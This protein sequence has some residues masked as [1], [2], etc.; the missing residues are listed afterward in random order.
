[1]SR[2]Q[3]RKLER[4][5]RKVGYQ[6]KVTNPIQGL[7]K[8]GYK[9][10]TDSNGKIKVG[11]DKSYNL[12][13]GLNSPRTETFD[14]SKIQ[15]IDINDIKNYNSLWE[16]TKSGWDSEPNTMVYPYINVDGEWLRWDNQLMRIDGG[17]YKWDSQNQSKY[18]NYLLT[19][20]IMS[21]T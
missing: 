20:N 13:E 12:F 5:Q 4:K 16:L 19:N 21:K 2:N 6:I 11:V 1:M 9:I 14:E 10:L 15:L 7:E 18:M 3:R 8:Y 17:Y